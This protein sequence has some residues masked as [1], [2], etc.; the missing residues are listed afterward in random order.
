MPKPFEF[1]SERERLGY[2]VRRGREKAGFA[3]VRE[4][5]EK[6]GVEVETLYYLETG[7]CPGTKQPTEESIR[8]IVKE[9][10]F[11]SLMIPYVDRLVVKV[12][13]EN[14]LPTSR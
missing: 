5:A 6:K 13:V 8:L 4:F 11:S 2:L 14:S 7:Y 9:L 10:D 12:I 1:T 3:T